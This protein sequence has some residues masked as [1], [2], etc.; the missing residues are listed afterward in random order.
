MEKKLEYLR[1]LGL[2]ILEIWILL[3]SHDILQWQKYLIVNLEEERLIFIWLPFSA[4][5]GR[6]GIADGLDRCRR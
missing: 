2:I 1:G 5:P 6:E 4:H 3:D